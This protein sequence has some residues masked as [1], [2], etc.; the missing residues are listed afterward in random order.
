VAAP[1]M[2]PDPSTLS[3]P[4]L[5]RTPTR[6]VSKQSYWTFSDVIHG[7]P[8]NSGLDLKVVGERNSY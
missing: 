1:E 5:A 3:R 2:A 4:P 7:M 6:L 8:G